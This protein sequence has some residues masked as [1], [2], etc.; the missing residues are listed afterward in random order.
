MICTVLFWACTYD[1]TGA[2]MLRWVL[3]YAET[4]TT[5]LNTREI[6]LAEGWNDDMATKI[7]L[8][9]APLFLILRGTPISPMQFC[10]YK[11]IY[12]K[13]HWAY[14]ITLSCVIALSFHW[15]Y[16]IWH[17][18]VKKLVEIFAKK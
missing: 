11:A 10:A 18:M 9:F 6:F 3:A 17:L 2:T 16:K 4:P 8:T 5:F 13:S 15:G 7:G 12:Q 14:K 1:G